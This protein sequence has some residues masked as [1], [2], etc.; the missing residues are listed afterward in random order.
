MSRLKARLPVFPH[1]Y[2]KGREREQNMVKVKND[3]TGKKFGRLTV[4]KQVED[5]VSIGGNHTAKWLC[6]C[7]CGNTVEVV[8]TKLTSNHTK[9]C[10]CFKGQKYTTEI[11]FERIK[12]N[13]HY[14][15]IIFHT[16][17]IKNAQ[18]R[19]ECEC[20]IDGYK[21]F[22]LAY[23]ILSENSGCPKCGGNIK[24]THEEFVERIKKIN[25]DI[26]PLG[27]Y[28]NTN[29]KVDLLCLKC[30]HKWSNTPFHL[31]AGEGCPACAN[32]H[33]ANLLKQ[34]IN[35]F[36]ERMNVVNPTIKIIGEYKNSGTHIKCKCLKCNHEWSAIP[37][38]LIKGTGCPNCSISK[39]EYKISNCLD[40]LDVKYEIQKRF[41]DCKYKR[42]LPFDFYLS[43]YNLCIEYDGEQHFH[44]VAFGGISIE[45]AKKNYEETT[46][47]DAIKNQYCKDNDIKLL[48][49]PYTE[50]K[51]IDE[52]LSKIL[53]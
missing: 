6:E 26:L 3:L 18:T 1:Y 11:F 8:G 27:K 15:D 10:G 19:L 46:I 36:K 52:I 16:K 38:N 41:D 7:E 5:H 4:L 50:F 20:K 45:E 42:L 43:D 30:G 25:P 12:K 9:S 44:P 17:E 14:S 34:D 21:W 29:T 32:Q 51:N 37:S 33:K 31:Y 49:I 13:P 35:V 48:R 23:K 47:K 28:T 22:P 39:G 2:F 24:I 53:N 40:T